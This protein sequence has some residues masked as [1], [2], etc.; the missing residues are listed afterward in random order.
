MSRVKITQVR[1]SIDR[2]QKQKRTLTALGLRKINGTVEHDLTD[3]IQG[4]ISKVSH[5]V[6]VEELDQA[7]ASPKTTSAAKA[8]PQ[9]KAAAPA[10]AVAQEEE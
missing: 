10:A 9:Q 7:T 6:K 2:S 5:L 1:S 4:M 3:T 8:A